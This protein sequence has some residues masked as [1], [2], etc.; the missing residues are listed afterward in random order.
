MQ[1][2]ILRKSMKNSL[3]SILLISSLFIFTNKVHAAD[4]TQQEPTLITIKIGSPDGQH[5]FSPDSLTLETG[6][7][8]KLRLENTGVQAYYF[9]SH[10]IVDAVYTRKVVVRD[11]DEKVI[12]EIYGPVRRFEIAT[13]K[14]IEWWIYPVRT[15]VFDDVISTKKLALDGMKATITVK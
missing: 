13:G 8:Y 14:S 6:K 15:G 7:L 3:V 10:G 4:L 5:R 12:A 11:S 2:A 1:A 9:S